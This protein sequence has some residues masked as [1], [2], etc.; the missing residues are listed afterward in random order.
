MKIIIS[1]EDKMKKAVGVREPKQYGQN[2]SPIGK[3][4]QDVTYF[5]GFFPVYLLMA[6]VSYTHLKLHSIIWNLARTIDSPV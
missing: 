2:A 1:H 5:S 6:A 3:D 4:M